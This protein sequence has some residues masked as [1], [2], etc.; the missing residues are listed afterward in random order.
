[1][2]AVIPADDGFA[3]SSPVYNTV[4]EGYTCFLPRSAASTIGIY[5]SS[6]WA[7]GQ[8]HDGYSVFGAVS[9]PLNQ[10][11]GEQANCAMTGSAAVPLAVSWVHRELTSALDADVSIC[12]NV[13][14]PAGGVFASD[15]L[16]LVGVIARAQAG[17]S[18][19][20]GTATHTIADGDCYAFGIWNDSS[21]LA[22]YQLL[23]VNGGTVTVLQ[24]G[25]EFG[26]NPG[27]PFDVAD[28]LTTQFYATIP[29]NLR[30]E[31]SDEAGDV[32]L[33]GYREH[34]GPL[35][36]TS[37]SADWN[38]LKVI[39][40]L[41]TSVS[42]ITTAGRFGF[43]ASRE[44]TV[45][46]VKSVQ[47]VHWL[48]VDV[49]G[50]T[51]IL[52]EFRRVNR[53]L[54][55]P[56]TA[57]S[58]YT[59][60]A[61][62]A[63]LWSGD[64]WGYTG[65]GSKLRISTP[66]GLTN[67]AMID[68]AV[69]TTGTA[70]DEGTAAFFQYQRHAPD[71]FNSRRVAEFRISTNKADGTAGVTTT[72]RVVGVWMRGAVVQG[73]LTALY[74]GYSVHVRGGIAGVCYVKLRRWNL[75]VGTVIAEET[76]AS[77][78]SFDADHTVDLE[79]YNLPDSEGNPDNGTVVLIV[80]L[81]GAQ[82]V[83]AV[84]SGV[85]NVTALASGT[86]YDADPARILNGT[87]EGALVLCPDGTNVV[88]LDDWTTNTLSGSGGLSANDEASISVA[89]EVDDVSG[90]LSDPYDWP[91]EDI[92]ET[93]TVD[94]E[95]EDGYTHSHN[96]FPRSRRTWSITASA[97]SLAER[98]TL[99]TF[100]DAHKGV[101]FNWTPTGETTAVKA[102]FGDDMLDYVKRNPGVHTYAFTLVEVF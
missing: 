96:R 74:T 58:G 29:F 42:R 10:L 46:S 57:A 1:M 34:S 92:T 12:T 93:F 27:V 66:A 41:D 13:H 36:S 31:V 65:H 55:T 91:V 6:G 85:S 3:E 4:H 61:S 23:R 7:V 45:S 97:V 30:L 94:R 20:A 19:G 43:F 101:S 5:A 69:A 88:Y 38:S 75:G 60:G 90:T 99:I 81:D 37:G 84:A 52:D 40:Y 98:T 44:N 33:R 95:F 51:Q 79:A 86:I 62:L 59:S 100:W 89:G 80:K 76:A 67:R 53:S 28:T 63:S 2:V 48:R 50:T 72:A 16:R 102:V 64:Y 9:G 82:V 70:A 15:M 71:R 77:A 83:L 87:H 32:R 14:R 49:N 78:F 39:D 24:T 21:N 17:T 8:M 56:V 54:C 26:A 73:T 68:P 11:Y 47:L 22:T 35:G 25:D 18:S